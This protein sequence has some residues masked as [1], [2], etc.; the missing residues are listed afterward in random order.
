[1][2]FCVRCG[3]RIPEGIV[4]CPYCGTNLKEL[5]TGYE[6]PKA[7]AEPQ[8][9]VQEPGFMEERPT[10]EAQPMPGADFLQERPTVEARP[11][12][13]E[14]P[15]APV[16]PLAQEQPL[17]PVQP[18][19]PAQP[20]V[21]E[22]PAPPKQ[23]FSRPTVEAW[24]YGET[25]AEEQELPGEVYEPVHQEPVHQE[26]VQQEP[27]PRQPYTAPQQ[28]YTAPQ[29]PYSAPRQPDSA[30]Q[31][32]YGQRQPFYRQPYY[33]QQED[34]GY[35]HAKPVRT[36]AGGQAVLGRLLGIFGMISSIV[37]MMAMIFFC[38]IYMGESVRSFLQVFEEKS[39]LL[40]L[41]ALEGLGLS[42][43]GVLLSR[44]AA[45]K[46][47]PST[48]AG[49]RLGTVGLVLSGLNLADLILALIVLLMA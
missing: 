7:A 29:Q 23:T 2:A 10:V 28:P 26:P 22:Q 30:Q 35:L 16:Q 5:M 6:T 4:F 20:P 45:K 8:P 17:A 3:K 37:V 18:F 33:T 32:P 39:L 15:F 9:P 36:P 47:N 42:L 21:Q 40:F 27:A 31:P 24:P 46:G 11:L 12:S 14:Q 19:A 48:A 34:L 13:P 1:M 41:G 49:K 44:S 43:A 25:P 38:G